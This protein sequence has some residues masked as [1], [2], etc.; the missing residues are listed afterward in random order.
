M[1]R[2]T[3]CGFECMTKVSVMGI[4]CGYVGLTKSH[5]YFGKHY[6]EIEN[7]EVHGGLTFSGYWE[8]FQDDL[9][10]LGFD[11]GHFWDM[12]YQPTTVTE[13]PYVQSFKSNKSMAYVEE[14][15]RSLAEQLEKVKSMSL[16]NNDT[17]LTTSEEEEN[18]I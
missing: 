11:C 5:P 18:G 6:N 8:E 14:E 15:T 13:F 4:P 10:Y 3:H 1:M 2:F 7:I 9:W 17:V 12:A 16:I